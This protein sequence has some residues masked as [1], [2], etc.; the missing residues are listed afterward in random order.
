MSSCSRYLP[1]SFLPDYNETLH[2]QAK[3]VF[4][5]ELEAIVGRL[6]QIY[7]PEQAYGYR[8]Y[9]VYTGAAGI[10]YLF[11]RLASGETALTCYN[12]DYLWEKAEMYVGVSLRLVEDEQASRRTKA[13]APTRCS[14]FLTGYA[15]VYTIASVIAQSQQNDSE[16]RRYKDMVLQL[17]PELSELI[18]CEMLYGYAG[19]L[20]CILFLE[21]HCKLKMKEDH[22]VMHMVQKLLNHIWQVGRT[23][24]RQL[25][26]PFPLMWSW[27][28]KMYL[29]AAHGICGILTIL[30]HFHDEIVS[31]GFDDDV[32]RTID[33]L[34]SIRFESGNLPSSIGSGPRQLVHWCHG[35]PGLVSLLCQAMKAYPSDRG[36]YVDCLGETVK[37]ISTKG[38]LKKGFGICHGISGNSFALLCASRCGIDVCYYEQAVRFALFS[39]S[40]NC[41]DGNELKRSLLST[42][43]CPESLFEGYAG[44]ACLFYYFI[45]ESSSSSRKFVDDGCPWI[46]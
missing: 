29:G 34:L 11:W 18:P 33:K 27:H 16:A 3:D 21:K 6:E 36:R 12:L 8:D 45:D 39:C 40:P 19:Y 41:K 2:P 17:E 5:S 20:S 10:A 13:R 25:K 37:V 38:L 23:L 22:K 32:K 9:S 4:M 15:G 43:D 24:S 30:L 46:M 42:P 14:T 7:S 31:S 28:G 44:L 1:T 35:A 26:S